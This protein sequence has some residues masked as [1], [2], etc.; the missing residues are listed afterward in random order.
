MRT[1][2]HM[3]G[4][5]GF[6]LIELLVVVAIMAILMAIMMPALVSAREQAK[7]LACSSNLRQLGLAFHMYAN[8]NNGQFPAL[9]EEGNL[10]NKKWWPNKIAQY[11]PVRKWTDI[12]YGNV[13][14]FET[15]NNAWR[16]PSLQLMY[17]NYFGGGY[18]TAENIIRYPAN[19]G[20][21]RPTQ[22]ASPATLFLLGEGW[23]EKPSWG[24]GTYGTYIS[25]LS[26]ATANWG[27][28]CAQAA[29]R[30]LNGIVTNI[31]FFDGHGESFSIANVKNN[32]NGLFTPDRP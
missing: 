11:I 6:T 29:P 18:C 2:R 25:I 32:T 5:A 9:N 28:G 23:L 24:A 10:G 17:P 27:T 31:S 8:E 7:T 1:S 13:S 26:P 12:A 3:P 20:S 30:H 14:P 19:G 21:Y 15:T 16:C 4:K 22:V